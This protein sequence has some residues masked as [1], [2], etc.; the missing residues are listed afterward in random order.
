MREAVE[1]AERQQRREEA[2]RLLTERRAGRP[3]MTDEAIHKARKRGR[4]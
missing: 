4:P 1:E 2:F 3:S